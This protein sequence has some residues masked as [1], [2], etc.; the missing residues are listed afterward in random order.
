MYTKFYDNT[1]ITKFIKQLVAKTNVPFISTWKPGDFAIRGMFYLTRDAIWKCQHTGYPK[2]IDDMCPLEHISTRIGTYTTDELRFFVRVSPYVFGEEYFGITGNYQS[3]ILGYDATT[4]FYL[5]QYLRMMRDIFDLDM[6]PF[7]NCFANE[8]IAD[9]NFD[10]T[11]NVYSENTSTSIYKVLSVPVRFGKTYMISI[12]SDVP[13]EMVCAIY[14]SKGI[15]KELT[16]NLNSIKN[17]SDVGPEDSPK[18]NTYKKYLRMQFQQPVFYNT[19]SWHQLYS[20]FQLENGHVINNSAYDQRLGQFEKYLRLLIKIPK[21]NTS[22]VVVIEG[23]YPV[24]SNIPEPPNTSNV[25]WSNK[26]L[27]S[28][29]VN[30]KTVFGDW[31]RPVE[32]KNFDGLSFISSADGSYIDRDNYKK[33]YLYNF[34]LNAFYGTSSVKLINQNIFQVANSDESDSSRIARIRETI[35]NLYSEELN[36][37][38]DNIR[39]ITIIESLELENPS[40]DI[41]KEPLL[42]PLSLL[43]INDGNIYAFSDRLVE[44]LVQNVINQLDTFTKD[45][46]RVQRYSKSEINWLKNNSRYTGAVVPGVWDK[47]FQRY[48][49]DLVKNSNIIEKKL[50]L[51]GYVDKDTESVITRGQEV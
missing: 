31:V 6:M 41:Q 17:E 13:V 24:V 30:S 9:V 38:K 20:Q 46:D 16:N 25:T 27:N 49:F 50:D 44:Y 45:I 5:G 34:N 36:V 8:L 39:D 26:Y 51:T 11:G 28:T 18:H 12:D 43:Q 33:T 10:E 48:L 35:V 32:I 29:T 7:Y 1:I 2:G 21:N 19:I 42:S 47:D 3:K 22:S 40:K 14:G 4:H 37:T 15:I 23:D